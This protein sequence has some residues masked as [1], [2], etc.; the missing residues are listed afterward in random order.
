VFSNYGGYKAMCDK[1][2]S[3]FSTKHFAIDLTSAGSWINAISYHIDNYEESQ[4]RTAELTE[5]SD[6]TYDINAFAEK[7]LNF[8]T[9][10]SEEFQEDWYN[11][12]IAQYLDYE[13]A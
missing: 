13:G 10:R 11:N 3:N 4:K 1:W 12:N 8:Y 7:R 9:Q 5:W 2:P 6:R